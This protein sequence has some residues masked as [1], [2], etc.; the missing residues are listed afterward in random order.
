MAPS[1]AAS[2]QCGH[3]INASTDEEVVFLQ[4]Q[5]RLIAHFWMRLRTSTAEEARVLFLS[6][7]HEFV[8]LLVVEG[9]YIAIATRGKRYQ[10]VESVPPRGKQG[11]IVRIPHRYITE[12]HCVRTH[13]RGRR[14][15]QQ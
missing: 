5:P 3:L 15:R 12:K 6:R 13:K 2:P 14:T 10:T 4:L 1:S 11:D 8:H 9:S 7:I